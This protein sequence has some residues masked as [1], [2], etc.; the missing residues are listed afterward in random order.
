MTVETTRRPH[1]PR[2][3]VE[4]RQNNHDQVKKVAIAAIVGVF[5]TFVFP[6]LVVL[7]AIILAGLFI[8]M[9]KHKFVP[10]VVAIGGVALALALIRK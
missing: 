1:P 4:P 8:A 10:V 3:E 6:G 5:A 9:K 7:S 2:V